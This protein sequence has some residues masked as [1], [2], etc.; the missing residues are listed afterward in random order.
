MLNT[1][2][3]LNLEE[4]KRKVSFFLNSSSFEI[5]PLKI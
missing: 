1:K 2:R 3:I 5:K 4:D